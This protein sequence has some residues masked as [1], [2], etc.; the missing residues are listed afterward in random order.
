MNQQQRMHSRFTVRTQR[1]AKAF[2]FGLRGGM[3]TV[4]TP[5]LAK[6]CRQAEQNLVS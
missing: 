3:E 1:S 5:L 2:R 4:S 6:V